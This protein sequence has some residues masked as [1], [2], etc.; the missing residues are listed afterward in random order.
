MKFLLEIWKFFIIKSI[1]YGRF[2]FFFFF[3][4]SSTESQEPTENLP[5]LT[6]EI[7]E[8]FFR[9]GRGKNEDFK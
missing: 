5:N 2:F 7:Q 8:S 1:E 4:L 3:L 9:K 6:T